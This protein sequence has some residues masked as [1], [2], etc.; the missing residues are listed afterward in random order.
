[1]PETRE[2]MARGLVNDAEIGVDSAA[3][4]VTFAG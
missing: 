3:V 4:S 1:V 2:Y